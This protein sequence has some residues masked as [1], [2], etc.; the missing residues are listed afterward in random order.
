MQ[1]SKISAFCFSVILTIPLLLAPRLAHSSNPLEI[2][3][4]NDVGGKTE[5]CG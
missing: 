2:F 3:Y 5:P 4:S 1:P